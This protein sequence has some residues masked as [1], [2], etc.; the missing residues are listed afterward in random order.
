MEWYDYFT[1]DFRGTVVNSLLETGPSR[2]L[3]GFSRNDA[4]GPLS[5]ALISVISEA[6]GELWA[7]QVGDGMSP[8]RVSDAIESLGLSN[9]NL[10]FVRELQDT[11]DTLRDRLVVNEDIL[12]SLIDRAKKRRSRGT[13]SEYQFAKRGM[14]AIRFAGKETFLK[15]DLKGAAFI[16]HLIRHQG[17]H[18]HVIRLMADV[19]GAE[20]T[21]IV[22][23]AEGLET[24]SAAADDAAD[25]RTIK[26]CEARYDSLVA[27]REHAEGDR[28]SEI[29]TE[30]SK[31]AAYL[32][33]A[34]G[35]GKR[36]RKMGDEVAAARRR[37]ARVIN[38]AIDKIEKS[39]A[40][41]ATHL[42]NSIRT[43]TEMVYEPDREVDWVLT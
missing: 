38:I 3:S 2:I 5:K 34:L 19:A 12:Y 25:K 29:E 6:I 40:K 32:S 10:P 8:L 24:D 37:I 26:E 13:L 28:V 27:E 9:R 14:W 4:V 43:Y 42:R 21:K 33:S 18:I 22:A 7:T 16:H 31:I 36:S 15:G 11:L 17:M 39:D 30:I 41:L 23:A 1:D 35:L 20:R